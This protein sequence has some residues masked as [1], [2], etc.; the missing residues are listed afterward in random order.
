MS[1]WQA[2]MAVYHEHPWMVFIMLGCS[3]L[4]NGILIKALRECIEQQTRKATTK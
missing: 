1:I 4:I 2:I 3:L